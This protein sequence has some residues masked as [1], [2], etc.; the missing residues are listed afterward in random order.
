MEFSRQEHFGIGFHFLSQGLNPCLLLGGGFFTTEPP[1]N[2]ESESV[3]L[4][5]VSDS[6]RPH[7]L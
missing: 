5:V 3:S 4:S 2:I 1:G 7:G 6:L